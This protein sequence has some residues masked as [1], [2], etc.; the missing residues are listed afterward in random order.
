[1]RPPIPYYGGKQTVAQRIV[2]LMPPHLH[3]VEPYAG[4]L[5]V[6]LAKTPARMETVNDLDGNLMAFWRTLRDHPDDLARA[7]QLTPHSRAEYAACREALR[8]NTEADDLERAR[9]AWVCLTQG[10]GGTLRKPTGWRH[11]VTPRGSSIGMPGYLD[12]YV[13]RMTDAAE[14][15]H[16]VSLESMPALDL[17]VK[18]GGDSE[19]LLYV[20]PPYVGSTRSGE[21]QYL[22][23]MRD[24]ASHRELSEALHAARAVV[25]LSGY[26]SALYDDLYA[27]WSQVQ[28]QTSSGN[29]SGDRGTARTE[30]L[31]SNRPM[32][33]PETL[34]DGF[35]A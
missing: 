24:D 13:E 23:E 8:G 32:A 1:M 16:D 30:V 11:F 22:H 12:G 9:R 26:G 17:I 2:A 29:G 5:A 34:F 35:A 15:L 3:Y 21:D 10:R 28:I 19:A 33:L 27:G 20:D 4:S 7:C 6:L 18:Y 14:R 25:I 31:W